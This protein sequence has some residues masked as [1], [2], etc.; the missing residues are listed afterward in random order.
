MNKRL[1]GSLLGAVVLGLTLFAASML[2]MG[3]ISQASAPATAFTAAQSAPVVA[4]GEGSTFKSNQ[5]SGTWATIAPFPTISVSPTPG[6]Y[7][8]RIKRGGAAAYPPNGKVYLMGGRIG[9]DGEDS[10]L[11]SI[12]EY[13]PGDPGSWVR[14]SALLDGTLQGSIYSSNMAVVTLTDTSGVRIYAVG[15]SSVNSVPTAVVRVYDPVADTITTLTSDAW[16][17]S[18]VRIPGG[19]AVLNNK[20]YIF[21]GFSSL[22]GGQVFNDTWVFDPMGASGQKWTQLTGAPLSLARGYIAGASLDGKLYAIGG[23]T[24]DSSSGQLV[25]NDRVERLDPAVGTWQTLASLPTARGDMGA[26]AYNTGTPYEIAGHVAV[27]GGV[28]PVP[29]AQGY[30]YDPGT[31]SWGAF[32]SLVNPTRNY[33][34]AQLN[35]YLYAL[36]GYDYS[37][38]TPN[39][40]GFNQRYD[41][42]TPSGSPTPTVTGT[43]P[44]ST[45]TQT[46]TAVPTGTATPCSINYTVATSTATIV[47]GVV[48][49]GNHCDDCTTS[50]NLPFLVRLYDRPFTNAE[51]GSNG[52]VSFDIADNAF[53]NNCLPSAS[54]TYQIFPHWDDLRTDASGSG[55][56]TST[57]GTAPNR[58]LHIEWRTTYFSGGGTANFEVRMYEAQP[59]QFDIVYGTVTQNAVSATIGVQ[60]DGTLFTQYSCNT[61][62][63]NINGLDL[64]FTRPTNSCGTGTAV[65]TGTSTTTRTSTAVA[66]GTNTTTRTGTTVATDVPTATRT[67]TPV[68]T[69]TLTILPTGTGTAVATNTSTTVATDTAAPTSTSVVTLTTISTSTST[70][71][72][73][74]TETET[75]VAGTA[76]ATPTACNIQFADVPPSNTFYPFVQCL[77]CRNI[78]GGYPCGGAGEPC[79]GSNDPYYRPNA[80]I[81]RGQI[82]KIVALSD[83][84]TTFPGPRIYE[85]VPESS[86]FYLWIQQLSNEGV[87]GGYPCGQRPD[88]PCIAPDNRPYF[89][90]NSPASRGQL[91]KIVSNAAGFSE[92]VSRQTY[93][94]VPPTSPFYVWVERLSSRNVMGGYP[95]GGPGEPCDS[96]NRPYFRPNANVTRGQAAKI[97]ANTFFPDC[98]NPAPTATVVPPAPTETAT[99]VPLSTSTAVLPTSTL[100][101]PTSTQ[102]A[103]AVATATSTSIAQP[104]ATVEMRDFAYMPEQITVTLGMSVSWTNSDQVYHTVTSDTGLFASG[105]IQQGQ[106]Y[107]RQFNDLGDFPYYCIPHPF[108]TG[109]VHVV[110]P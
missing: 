98:S 100:V 38:G 61:T 29:D 53:S 4:K 95:C 8:A 58:T 9:V 12:F 15:G 73:T 50:F 64:T 65:A 59:N 24:F 92:P 105:N 75:V 40:A 91:S 27:A 107:T 85:D 84:I 2:M 49:V 82:S 70:A 71:V 41:A 79:N 87:M 110:A 72:A 19:Y 46:S 34:V 88:E 47:A 26:W 13:T 69:S 30:L 104:I 81:T 80:S 21:G 5:P 60:K 74:S 56:F 90:P 14:K 23:D 94:D 37:N 103:T 51:V 28:Y 52:I 67:S 48:D 101:P 43:L 10:S 108:M 45:S 18:P 68:A 99:S 22:S 97:D 83:E 36:G 54:A 32:P 39:A 63:N 109:T 3:G 96:Q 6:S 1:L 16:P 106:M 11:R 77:A 7:P 102:V 17:A 42:T 44:T 33:G 78:I 31:N 20:L 89:R 25:P 62:V 35:G 86:P 93:T 57:T 66:T 76:T 55:I